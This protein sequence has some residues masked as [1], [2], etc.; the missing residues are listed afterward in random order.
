M[1]IHKTTTNDRAG[2][3]CAARAMMRDFLEHGRELFDLSVASAQRRK[4]ATSC[5]R[6]SCRVVE[7]V[8][9]N[10]FRGR[11]RW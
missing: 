9:D 10:A 5:D 3:L 2:K 6:V 11:R 8:P 7:M 4:R 1:P